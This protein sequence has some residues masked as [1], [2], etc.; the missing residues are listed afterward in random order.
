MARSPDSARRN[1]GETVTI[2]AASRINQFRK[3]SSA[4]SQPNKFNTLRDLQA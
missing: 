2:H 3:S 1:S 4:A